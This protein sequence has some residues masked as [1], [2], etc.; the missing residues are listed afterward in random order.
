MVALEKYNFFKLDS[1]D[2]GVTIQIH[3]TEQ[4]ECSSDIGNRQS[5]SF[6]NSITCVSLAIGKLWASMSKAN[7]RAI[8]ANNTRHSRLTRLSRK[9]DFG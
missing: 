2:T 7:D 1:L 4:I 6:T 9:N 8:F 3:F 5:P